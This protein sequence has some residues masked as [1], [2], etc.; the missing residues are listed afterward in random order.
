[1]YLNI[2]YQ[3]PTEEEESAY[4]PGYIHIW[5]DGFGYKKIPFVRYAYKLDPQGQFKTMYGQ[6]CKKVRRWGKESEASGQIYE[7]DVNPETRYLIDNYTEY[8]AL[9]ESHVEMFFDIEVDATDG[10]PNI[11]QADNKI[12]AISYYDKV[13]KEYVA[14]ILDESREI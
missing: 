5:D 9:P 4:S 10:L 6:P 12:T 1:M 14:L 2:F 13:S 8:D 11:K 3:R 7:G